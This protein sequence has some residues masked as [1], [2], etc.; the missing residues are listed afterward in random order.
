MHY[1]C[2]IIK[3]AKAAVQSSVEILNGIESLNESLRQSH[4]TSPQGTPLCLSSDDRLRLCVSHFGAVHR[5]VEDV[6]DR[7][8]QA[9]T[10]VCTPQWVRLLSHYM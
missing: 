5:W 6:L 10:L 4:R 2:E 3:D 8:S 1:R 7:A 9:S